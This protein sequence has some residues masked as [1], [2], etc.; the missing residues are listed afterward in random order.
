MEKE[1]SEK[2]NNYFIDVIESM[3]IVEPFIMEIHSCDPLENIVKKKYSK[4][5]SIV[6]IM[7]NVLVDTK[8]SFSPTTSQ[9]LRT[10]ILTL[11]PKKSHI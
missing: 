10:Q 6:K 3:D 11:K 8:Y 4:H 9:E 1:V 7:E 5:T 2:L